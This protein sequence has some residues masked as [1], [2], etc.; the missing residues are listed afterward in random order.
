MNVNMIKIS[1]LIGIPFKNRGRGPEEYDCYGL[2][3]EIYRRCG[4]DIPDYTVN[5]LD[6][7]AVNAVYQEN[8]KIW[9]PTERPEFPDV[10]AMK[11]NSPLV[12]HVGVYLGNHQFVHAREGSNSCIE[13]TEHVYWKR[14]IVAYYKWSG[15]ND[16][17]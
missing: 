3:Q 10:L 2:V 7:M 1:D 14:A 15:L 6:F 8:K 12:N 9:I 11:F 4:I 17:P 5:A 16:H 13:S